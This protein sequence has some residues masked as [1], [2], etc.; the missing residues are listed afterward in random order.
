MPGVG[1]TLL[2]KSLARSIDATF[3]RV[4]FT[5]DLLPADI[6]GTAIYNQ[7]LA[8]FVFAPGP[9][10]ANIVLADEINRATPRTQAALLEAMG[11]GQVSADRDVV[12]ATTA[13]TGSMVR[14]LGRLRGGSRYL[15]V[16]FNGFEDVGYQR[17]EQTVPGVLHVPWRKGEPPRDAIERVLAALEAGSRPGARP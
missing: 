4:Q 17:W 1:K 9:L 7:K 8:E 5:S 3:R 2:A 11:E 6:T 14:Q 16:H 13:P 12:V 10:F 15:V